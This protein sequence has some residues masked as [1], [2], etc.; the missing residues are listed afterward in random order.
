MHDTLNDNRI[1]GSICYTMVMKS[2]QHQSIML[3]FMILIP[4]ANDP[5]IIK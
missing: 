5:I 2:G 1:E 4:A 3:L